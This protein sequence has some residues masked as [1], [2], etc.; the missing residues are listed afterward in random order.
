MHDLGD[1]QQGPRAAPKRSLTP[2]HTRL[3]PVVATVAQLLKNYIKATPA[4]NAPAAQ[5]L[6]RWAIQNR[7]LK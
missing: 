3:S 4:D 6:A 5:E 1:A 2:I 7:G